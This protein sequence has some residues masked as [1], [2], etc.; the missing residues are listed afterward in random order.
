VDQNQLLS[1]LQA[2]AFKDIAGATVS[3][4]VPIAATLV[5]RLAA[6]ALSGTA[7]PVRAVEIGPHAGDRFDV[8]VTTAWPLVPQ[9]KIS[10]TIERQPAFPDSPVL[11]LRW[12]FLGGLG[13]LAA[14]FTQALKNLPAGVR[15]ENDRLALDLPTLAAGTAAAPVLPYVKRVEL[16]TA[17]DHLLV[18]V[19]LSTDQPMTGR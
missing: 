10:M 12:S 14:R 7:L 6:D 5:N 8:V 16:H 9:L 3:L 19:D 1:Y 2:S 13:A 4:R 18:E 11:L 15:I 17:E